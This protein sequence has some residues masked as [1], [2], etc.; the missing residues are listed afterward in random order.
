MDSPMA[1]TFLGVI[2]VAVLAMAIGQ[3]AAFVLAAQAMRRVGQAADQMQ[4]DVRPIVANLQAMSADAARATERATAQVE[5][6]E[7]MVDDVSS[8]VEDTVATL[9]RTILAPARDGLAVIQGLKA[10][11]ASF[12]GSGAKRRSG[13]QGPVPVVVPDAGDDEDA[14]F[15]G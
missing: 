10:A 15:I 3:V 5:R 7:R 1:V 13:T 8:R 14:S 9:Q 2:A 6:V 4:R 12:R 11:L